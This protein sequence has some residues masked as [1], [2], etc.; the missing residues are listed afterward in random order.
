VKKKREF[1]HAREQD[2]RHI[3]H[4]A[5]QVLLQEGFAEELIHEHVEEKAMSVAK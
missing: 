5:R 3:S 2:T 1:L 4:H